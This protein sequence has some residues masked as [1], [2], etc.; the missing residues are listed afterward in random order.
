MAEK[1]E[2]EPKVKKKKGRSK[3]PKLVVGDFPYVS[4]MP[5]NRLNAIEVEE[6]KGKWIKTV[7]AGVV[8]AIVIGVAAVGFKVIHQISYDNAKQDA[9]AVEASILEFGEVDN[10]LT[11]KTGIEGEITQGSANS[12]NWQ[13]LQN[14]ISQN[15]PGGSSITTFDVVTG[16]KEGDASSAAVFVNVSALEPLDYA[17]ILDSFGKVSGIIPDSL[18]IGDLTST[19]SDG[20]QIVYSYPVSFTVD[21]TVLSQRW[22]YLTDKDAPKPEAPEAI[23]EEKLPVPIPDP[24]EATE[25]TE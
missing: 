21:S 12:I 8:I 15:L 10:A 24:A 18:L 22:K 1:T 13:D 6:A 25:E 5:A 23:Q 11:I 7:G 2:K 9:A 17:Q 16:G 19:G 4:L 20:S 3:G 14:R